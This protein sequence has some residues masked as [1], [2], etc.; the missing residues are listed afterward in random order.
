MP[1]QD[2][3]G[4]IARLPEQPGVYLYYND[5]GETLY[6]G[7]ARVLRDR[8]RSYLGAQGMSPRHDALLREASR[9]ETIVT[10]SVVEALALE[11]HLIKQ[12]APKYN[13]LL[14]DD[15]NYPYLQLTT[16]E[17]FPRVL[18]A[19]HVE[20]NDDFYAG[21][22]MPAKLGRRTM[23]LTHR[24]FGMR[25]CNEVITGERGRP[26]LEYDIKRC[27]AP[28][29]REICS[30]EEYGVAVQ[31]TRLFLEGRNDELLDQ[32]KREMAEA[33]AEERF[34]RAA[35]LRD[36]IR[37]I[38][39]LRHRQQKMT[40]TELGDRDAFGL[41]VGAAG[42]VVQVFQV[43]GGKVVERVELTTGPSED[44]DGERAAARDDVSSEQDV[45]QAAIEQFYTDREA[46]PEIHVP[47]ELSRQDAD[48]LE[49]WLSDRSARRVRIVVPKR[50]E[51]RGLLE[52]AARNAHVA[53]QTRFNENVA[54]H[55]DA[56]ETLRVVLNLPSIPRRIEC[57]DISTIQGSETVASMVVCED[58]RM[59]RS[60]YRKFRIR[61]AKTDDRY[62]MVDI[63]EADP[64]SIAPRPSAPNHRPSPIAHR[65]SSIAHRPSPIAGRFL[66]D[67]ASMSEVVLRRYRKI[68]ESG[69]PFPDLIL[70]DGGKGQLSAAYEALEQ[71]GLSRLIAVGIAKKEELLFTREH[72]QPIALA[73]DSPALLLIQRIRDEAHRFAVTFHRDSRARRDFGSDLD[74][75]A[76]IGPRRRN[77]L[78][79]A[80][81]SLAG[82]RRANREELTAVVGAKCADAVL[83]HF[84]NS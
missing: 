10:D 34:E 74:R 56:L 47:I 6:V 51:K 21:P 32:L 12:R 3:K 57:F 76:G 60:E 48:V 68:M 75:I 36:A 33:A 80:F 11:N 66:D 84:A 20:K 83:A 44:V 79:R 41:K 4:Q 49:A 54:A 64:S 22:F 14:R 9:L 40:G 50:G 82:V 25:S 2:L 16:G 73:A 18:V 13:I 30:P 19:R 46:P 69:G 43:R 67:F 72:E 7:K 35:Q 53:Y 8:V 78:L 81:G 15:K 23:E 39:T 61:G 28:C 26:C 37:V 77:A 17:A 29:V 27:I 31:H 63:P 65:A 55:Y 42:A 1:I 59:K 58:G 38:E 52:L 62:S 5:A 71:L 24:L 70:I 45:L